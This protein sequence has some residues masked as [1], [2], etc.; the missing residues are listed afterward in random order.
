MKKFV[1]L[2]WMVITLGSCSSKVSMPSDLELIKTVQLNIAEP[3]GITIFQDNLYIVSD[4]KG[5]FYKTS[6]NGKTLQKFNTKF[7]DL[8]G[9]TLNPV[10]RNF[11]MVN[12]SKRMLVVLDSLGSLLQKIKIKGKQKH[13]N[14]GLEGICYVESEKAVYV[15]NESSP[16]QLLKLNLDGKIMAKL[17]LAISKD[18]SGICYE[19]SSNSFWIVSDESES[20]YNITKKG[21][22]IKSYKIPVKKAEGIVVYKDTVYIVSDSSKKLYIFKKSIQKV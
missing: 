10:T 22:L 6:L 11:W 20:I 12:E 16:T 14:S 18:I 17:T 5:T 4:H 8:E 2:L 21:E 1:L 9:I 13:Y 7:T 19:N 15:I 3:S